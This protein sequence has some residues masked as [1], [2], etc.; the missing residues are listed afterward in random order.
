MEMCSFF[1]P[2]CVVNRAKRRKISKFGLRRDTIGRLRIIYRP[3]LVNDG[4][5]LTNN[6]RYL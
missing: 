4:E 1:G 5:H 3:N 6:L 2:P